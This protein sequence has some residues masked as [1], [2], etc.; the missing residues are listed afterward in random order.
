MSVQSTAI[1]KDSKNKLKRNEKVL[2][3]VFFANFRESSW[4]LNEREWE[5]VTCYHFSLSFIGNDVC[6]S[7]CSANK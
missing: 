2:F 4:K 1:A 6:F 5:S 7:I 3:A